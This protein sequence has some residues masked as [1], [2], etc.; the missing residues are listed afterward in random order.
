MHKL[1]MTVALLTTILIGCDEGDSNTPDTGGAPSQDL[2]TTVPMPTYPEYTG[3]FAFFNF[4]NGLRQQL[5][6]GL[7]AQS[8]MLDTVAK[9]HAHYLDS[10]GTGD[11][12][13][14]GIENVQNSYFT[15]ATTQD[16]CSFVGYA[17]ACPQTGMWSEVSFLMH[18]SPY[19]GL[20]VLTQ[21][22]RQ[23]GISMH[24]AFLFTGMTNGP[25]VQLGYPAGTTPQRQ[26]DN[27]IVATQL[28]GAF[29]IQ[30]NEGETLSVD[31]FQVR[32][33][34]GNEISGDLVTSSTDP[35]MRVPAHAAMFVPTPDGLACN[36]GVYSVYFSGK[37]NG[38]PFT[39]TRNLTLT[40]YLYCG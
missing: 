32:D 3:E 6:L 16:R 8:T 9:N 7:L 28:W 38:T 12:I 10:S 14:S 5:G 31:T 4:V 13:V 40:P 25:E 22:T 21:G 15:G 17:G 23:I 37:R 33:S 34:I 24:S 1:S 18:P 26:P 36:G 20:L 35:R 39:L 2:Q 29:H 19:L 30:V 11:E 27:F